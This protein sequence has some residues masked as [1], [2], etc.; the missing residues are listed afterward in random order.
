MAVL[1]L[2]GT[3]SRTYFFSFVVVVVVLRES[4]HL[5]MN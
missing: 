2:T 4:D 1:E 5:V 3:L